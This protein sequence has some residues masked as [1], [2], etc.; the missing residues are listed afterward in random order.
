MVHHDQ[1]QKIRV[2]LS[3]AGPS[4]QYLLDK[5][6]KH[7]KQLSREVHDMTSLITLENCFLSCSL[8]YYL[9]LFL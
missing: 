9:K 3:R 8:K 4:K 2:I 7:A 1:L 6:A 5:S